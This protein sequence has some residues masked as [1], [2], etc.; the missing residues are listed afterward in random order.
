MRADG[1][2][3]GRTIQINS[4]NSDD[5]WQKK[6][7]STTAGNLSINNFWQFEG[8]IPADSKAIRFATDATKN[9]YIKNVVVYYK[10]GIKADNVDFGMVSASSAPI[11]KTLTIHYANETPLTITSFSGEGFS[12][13]SLAE[14]VGCGVGTTT[15]DVTFTPQTQWEGLIKSGSIK[16]SNGATL[17]VN[18]TATV[19]LNKVQNF[20]LAGKT[21]SSVSLSWTTQPYAEKYEITANGETRTVT[22]TSYTWSGLN[23]AT[24]YDFS[25]VA[26]RGTQKSEASVV[27]VRT[28]DVAPAN[29]AASN[30]E[31][32]TMTLSWDAVPTVTSDYKLVN[33]TTG[34]SQRVSG[35]SVD[36][37]G[38]TAETW[39]DFDLYSMHGDEEQEKT[40]LK[41]RTELAGSAEV[42]GVGYPTI[43]EALEVADGKTIRILCNTSENIT[44]TNKAFINGANKTI[45]NVTIASTGSLE[46][47]T[48]TLNAGTF[49]I[50]SDSKG[51]HYQSGQ[52]YSALAEGLHLSGDSYAEIAL[53]PSGVGDDNRWYCFTV[54]FPVD[55]QQGVYKVNNDGSA[56]KGAWF[57]TYA[58]IVY[59]GAARAAMDNNE[60]KYYEGTLNPGTLYQIGTDGTNVW[61]FKKDADAP[62]V[63]E[64]TSLPLNEYPSE[65]AYDA[66][67]NTLGSN[68]LYHVKASVASE[69]QASTF[70]QLYKNG[71]GHGAYC[72]YTT[73]PLSEVD[74]NVAAAFFLQYSPDMGST[75][76]FERQTSTKSAAVFATSIYDVRIG[77]SGSEEYED[78][79]FVSAAEDALNEYQLGYDVLKMGD[80]GMSTTAAMWIRSYKKNLSVC[81]A[82]LTAKSAD[83]LMRLYAP[84]AG[85]YDLY[86]GK[87]VPGNTTLYLTK[88][89]EIV[90]DLS[91]AYSVTLAQGV[92]TQYG[93]R[94]V[95]DDSE[96]KAAEVDGQKY[97]KVQEAIDDAEGSEIVILKDV[98]EDITISNKVVMKGDGHSVGNVLVTKSGSLELENSLTATDFIIKSDSKGECFESGEYFSADADALT[99]TGDAYIDIT[100]DPSGTGDG[101]KWYSFTVPFPVDS[102]EGVY[103]L[104]AGVATKGVWG[105]T[106]LILEYDGAK[107]ATG[108]KGWVYTSGTLVPGRFYQIGTDGTNTFRFKKTS[109]GALVT[110]ETSV[111][112]NEYASSQVTDAGWNAIG[113]NS[114]YH[115]SASVAPEAMFTTFVQVYENGNGTGS[116]GKYATKLMSEVDFNVAAPF[117]VQYAPMM[118]S[119]VN[120]ERTSATKSA[121]DYSSSLFDV[122]IAANGSTGY[123]DRLFVSAAADAKDEYEIGYDVAKMGDVDK[124]SNALLWVKAYNTNL[125]VCRAPLSGGSAEF[126]MSVYAPADG[127]YNLYLGAEA[128][129]NA[130]LYL[131]KNGTKVAD[132]SDGYS[133]TLQKGVNTKYGLLIEVDDIETSASNAESGNI[134]VTANNGIITIS[135]IGVG[136]DYSIFDVSGRT[137]AS[138]VASATEVKEAVVSDASS[139][140]LI[141]KVKDKIVKV[142][143]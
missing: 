127:I 7:W 15:I 53:D 59:D 106:Y 115:V 133:I 78:R 25:I 74:L 47:V 19:I 96:D 55:A 34:A 58:I 50:R 17:D 125:S 1:V 100:L 93:L 79:L 87:D 86:I 84:E 137:I 85:N 111:A 72:K 97:D 41:V 109:D 23:S 49:I 29:F 12:I 21:S 117:F 48:K 94:I 95:V 43:A 54:P 102:R 14:T 4:K 63:T 92:T 121:A 20:A 45:G 44:V 33:R 129:G 108:A 116:N 28:M 38:L 124:G 80:L 30:I 52:Y 2:A 130:T 132:L 91:E 11:H 140:I 71:D 120:F 65:S 73:M 31:Q 126:D 64:E 66:G 10:T 105:S 131:T 101:N 8:E 60:W 99:L 136:D 24:N 27:S 88:D 114:L 9:I 13:G 112:L 70:V 18:L 103:K 37:T 118:G 61:R 76:S 98:T 57:S 139:R 77:K 6:V 40:S 22:G 110:A 26:V 62:L 143:Y 67:W 89:G 142:V 113:N 135:N 81:R 69:A 36:L 56:T 104:N 75:L 107:R 35:T 90:A 134:V 16:F 5:S 46:I 123:D 68:A 3:D 39:Y 128:D 138:G 32:T 82:P 122:R 83:F 42:D 119:V 141:V 51:D